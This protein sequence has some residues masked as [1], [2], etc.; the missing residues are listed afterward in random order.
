M[1]DIDNIEVS[2]SPAP[3]SHLSRRFLKHAQTIHKCWMTVWLVFGTVAIIMLGLCCTNQVVPFAT[4]STVVGCGAINPFTQES[5]STFYMSLFE[6]F[7]SNSITCYDNGSQD[8]CLPWKNELW[9]QFEQ[10]TVESNRDRMSISTSKAIFAGQVLFIL[11]LGFL[12]ASLILLILAFIYIGKSSIAYSLYLAV[13]YTF[14]VS[15][16]LGMCSIASITSSPPFNEGEWS[17]Y[18]SREDCLLRSSSTLP[19]VDCQPSIS[20]DGGGLYAGAVAILLVLALWSMF[21]ACLQGS[22]TFHKLPNPSGNS[23]RTPEATALELTSC[24]QPTVINAIS[25]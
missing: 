23:I 20:Y 4:L 6:G 19:Q 24:R 25:L 2:P 9:A 10:Y 3:H 16:A 1:L 18:F 7:S 17:S 21:S 12:L 8:F 5:Q 13:G 11:T 22:H 14:L 15:F